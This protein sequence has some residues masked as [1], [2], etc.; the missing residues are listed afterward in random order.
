[1]THI[2][3][4]LWNR[5]NVSTLLILPIFQDIAAHVKFKYLGY[6][7]PIIQL[8]M[9]HGL[10]NCY[11]YNNCPELGETNSESNKLYLVFS[12]N[13]VLCPIKSA[14]ANFFSLHEE[15]M[16]HTKLIHYLDEVVVV[17]L[18]IN[19]EYQKDVELIIQGKYSKVSSSYKKALEIT[20][21]KVIFVSSKLGY[22]ISIRNLSLAI[23]NRSESLRK[24]LED[25]L[26]VTLD[27][28]HEF[29]PVF[30]LDQETLTPEKL[31]LSYYEKK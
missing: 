24:E 17:V 18:N 5:I 15:L 20:A 9:D 25:I 10:L 3:R 6:K 13:D 29:Y 11:L 7:F 26:E 22:E 23:V 8:F 27:S 31:F 2:I 4:L 16:M 14:V 12:K 21:K 30:N 28:T 19:K 1:M